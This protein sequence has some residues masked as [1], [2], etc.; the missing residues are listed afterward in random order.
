MRTYPIVL[1]AV[2]VFPNLFPAPSPG[3]GHRDEP[4]TSSTQCGV[5]HAIAP[6]ANAMRSATG[7]DVSPYGLWQGTMMA[8]AFRDPYF[9]AQLQKE[10]LAVGDQVQEL[11]LRCHA[12]MAW[13]ARDLAGQPPPRLHDLIGDP[14]ATDGVSCT[15]CHLMDGSNFGKPASFS[16]H[17]A[18]TK[19]RKIFG[20]FAD[21]ATAPMQNMVRYT[22]TQG[23]HVRQAGLCGTCHTLF[24]E[25]QGKPFPEQTPYLEWRNSDFNDENGSSDE[26]RTCQQCHMPAVGATKIARNPMGFDFLIPP[27]DGYAAHAFVGGNAFMLDLLSDN[28]DELNVTAERDQLARM[29]AATRRQLGEA[30]ARLSVSAITRGDG[31]AN[32]AVKVENLTGHKFPTGYPARRAFLHVQVRVGRRVVFE[33]GAFDEQGRLTGI[34]DE[35]GQPHRREITAGDQV[36]IWEMVAGDGDGK[37]TTFLTAM[38]R[39]VKDNRLLPRGW[40]ADGPHV[41]DTAPVGVEGDAD[42]VGGSDT[43]AFSVPVPADARGRLQVVARLHYQSV[44]PG[45][46]DALRKVEHEDCERF[47]RMY[48]AMDLRPETVAVAI[49][50]EN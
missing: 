40:R 6:G 43:V 12:P 9:R 46:V 24:T 2:L 23:L 5:C 42:F 10:S 48:D 11:C 1:A 13:H 26:T 31:T 22:P 8:N 16:G 17:P 28:R 34:G 45:W 21:V 7:D 3:H 19:E 14:D 38:S 4:F 39:R 47:V 30:T 50:G 15:V 36:A 33:S 25:H 37:P 35:F 18:F 44:P 41:E 20:P 27:R 32:F 49:A 29:A